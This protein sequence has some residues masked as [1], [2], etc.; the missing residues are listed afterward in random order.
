[1]AVSFVVIPDSRQKQW[2][3]ATAMFSWRLRGYNAESTMLPT[4]ARARQSGT[5]P[6]SHHDVRTPPLPIRRSGRQWSL[7]PAASVFRSVSAGRGMMSGHMVL[8]GA[9]VISTSDP[10][11]WGGWCHGEIPSTIEPAILDEALNQPS[12]MC[13]VPPGYLSGRGRSLDL[14]IVRR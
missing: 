12:D 11:G 13:Q 1:M 14:A 9:R 8:A 4:G 10:T 5:S 2:G 7:C 6:L 3:A